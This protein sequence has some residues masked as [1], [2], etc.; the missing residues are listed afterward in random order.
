LITDREGS[1]AT[2][3]GSLAT[4]EGSLITDRDGSL[5]TEVTGKIVAVISASI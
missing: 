3:D 4:I 2:I 1:L 5:T